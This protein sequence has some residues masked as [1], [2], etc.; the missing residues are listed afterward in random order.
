ME[1]K[2]LIHYFPIFSETFLQASLPIWEII[3]RSG[4]ENCLV[5]EQIPF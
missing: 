2:N 1:T 5:T 4:D 3:S